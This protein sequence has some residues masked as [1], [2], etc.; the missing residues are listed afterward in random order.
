MKIISNG[1]RRKDSD[2]FVIIFSVVG[3]AESVT[4]RTRELCVLFESKIDNFV[5]NFCL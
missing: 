2:F 4:G 3:D 5:L 1:Q